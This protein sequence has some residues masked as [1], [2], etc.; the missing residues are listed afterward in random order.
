MLDEG[1]LSAG[2]HNFAESVRED[3]ACLG[4]TIG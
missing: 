4:R 1:G 2:L 3:I